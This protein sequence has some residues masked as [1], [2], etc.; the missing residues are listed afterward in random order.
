M[1]YIS[2]SDSRYFCIYT[3]LIQDNAVTVYIFLVQNNAVYYSFLIQDNAV[4]TYFFIQ[5]NAV[6][7][8]F[9]FEIIVCFRPSRQ[10]SV[11]SGRFPIFLGWTSI[12]QRIKWVS[13]QQPLGILPLSHRAPQFEIILLLYFSDLKWFCLYTFSFNTML[14]IYT[15]LV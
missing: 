5:N 9:W 7:I 4:Y 8:L 2:F 13:N 12:N 10:F 6:Y 14:Y 1:F 15:F 3:F 11:M